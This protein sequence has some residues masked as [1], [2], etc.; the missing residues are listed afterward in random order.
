MFERLVSEFP[1]SEYVS[2]AT[3]QITSLKTELELEDR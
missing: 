3:Q 2:E 1:D